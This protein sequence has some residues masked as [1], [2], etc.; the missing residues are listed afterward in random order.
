MSVDYRLLHHFRVSQRREMASRGE[1][2]VLRPDGNG[3]GEAR[4]DEHPAAERRVSTPPPA[5]A[6][7]PQPLTHLLNE[8]R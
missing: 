1:L 7:R 3:G 6:A 8:D 2:S 5:G 4:V